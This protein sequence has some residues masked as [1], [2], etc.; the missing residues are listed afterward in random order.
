MNNNESAKQQFN[1]NFVNHRVI[2]VIINNKPIKLEESTK[3][4]PKSST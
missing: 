3:K 1:S 4:D 2:N